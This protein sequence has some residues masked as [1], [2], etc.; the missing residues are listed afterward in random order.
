M[1]SDNNEEKQVAEY[2]QLLT[3][4]VSEHYLEAIDKYDLWL[5]NNHLKEE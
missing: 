5:T 2:Q 1:S 3:T 4:Q